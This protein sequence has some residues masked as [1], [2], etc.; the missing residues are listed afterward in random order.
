[1][2][3]RS[4]VG[5]LEPVRR[6]QCRSTPRTRRRQPC[7]GILCD[8]N[9]IFVSASN[10]GWAAS[11]YLANLPVAAVAEIHLAGHAVRELQQGTV[12]LIDDHGSRVAPDVWALYEEALNRFGDVPTLVEWDSNVPTLDVLI[13]EAQQASGYMEKTRDAVPS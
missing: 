6:R 1:M 9:N 3:F 12:L 10:H 11:D 8:V 13:G 2:L 5:P 4:R 7:C